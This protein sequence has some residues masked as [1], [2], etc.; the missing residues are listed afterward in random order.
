MMAMS[1]T[2]YGFSVGGE[3]STSYEVSEDEGQDPEGLWE[4]YL[5]LDNTEIIAPYLEMNLYGRYAQA[6]DEE[7]TDIYSAYLHFKRFQNALE[8]KLGRFTYAGNRFLTLDGAE[9]TIRTD[10][11]IGAAAFAGSPEY[12]DTD[13]RHISETF[14]D[15]GE[16][17]YGGKLFLNGVKNTTG[18]VSISK[19]EKDEATVQEC[20]GAGLGRSFSL[21]KAYFNL[22]GKMQYDTQQDNIYKG[23]LKLYMTYKNLTV[24]ADDIRYNIKD[25]SAYENELVISNFSSGQED[26][27]SYTVQ[28]AFT[29]SI[30]AYQSSV[31]THL[32]VVDGKMVEGNIYK[33][34]I[35]LDYYRTLGLTGNIE[36]YRYTGELSDANGASFALDLNLTRRLCVNFESEV[37]KLENSKTNDTIYSVYLSVG[38]DIL[39]RFTVGIFGE[40]S[41]ETRYLPENRY[42]ATAAYKF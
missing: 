8:V 40:N 5:R 32:E 30:I 22:G 31:H 24:M 12:F 14:R 23:A 38:Y 13:N 42:G 1:T 15:T 25:G 4:N 20:V 41:K 34:G 18:H 11:Y 3:L 28:Y 16:R 36:G 39:K 2:A 19:E 29:K 35:D 6:E 9:L 17:L 26:R 37:L 33:L 21:G 10:Y 7:E 27:I